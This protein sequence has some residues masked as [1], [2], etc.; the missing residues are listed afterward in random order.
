MNK[1]TNILGVNVSVLTY[2]LTIKTISSWVKNRQPHYVCVAAVHLIMECQADLQ[3]LKGVNQAGLVTPDGMPLAWL[4]KLYGQRPVE[5]VYGPDLMKLVCQKAV[6]KRW[7]IFLLGG[8][9][10]QSQQLKQVLQNTFPS[11]KIVGQLDTPI[12]PIP[13]EK[14][15]HIIKQINT[16]QAKIV[17]V[18]LGCPFQEQWMMKA[19][20]KLKQA[21]AI[22]VGAAFDFMTGKVRQAPSWLQSIGLEW[23]FRFAQEPKR[24][25]KRYFLFNTLF[26]LLIIK[27]LIG[28]LL[29]K[30]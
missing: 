5:R 9:K 19:A 18:G 13:D 8:A 17:F 2:S 26:S 3:L 21:V 10:G 25:A 14:N 15:R 27:Q 29:K 22:G 1:A 4:L 23:L 30:Q 6:Q 16:S 20:P 12:R 7:P 24:L 11:L 28:D